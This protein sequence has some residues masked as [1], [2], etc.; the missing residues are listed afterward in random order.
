MNILQLAV[1][2]LSLY[3]ASV[4][5]R[6]RRRRRGGKALGLAGL[7]VLPGGGYLGGHLSF[8]MGLDVNRTAWQQPP[9]QWTPA[10]ADPER[11]SPAAR[12]P[13][14]MAEVRNAYVKARTSM[15]PFWMRVWL[16]GDAVQPASAALVPRAAL[17]LVTVAAV[18]TRTR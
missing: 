18:T 12:R 13:S 15:R 14:P 11:L 1:T 16:R 4:V 3:L 5:A 7:G 2:A 8:V 6:A 9:H 17:T 10:L